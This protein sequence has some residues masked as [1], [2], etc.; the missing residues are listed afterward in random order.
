MPTTAE[1]VTPAQRLIRETHV[2]R[3]LIASMASQRPSYKATDAGYVDREGGGE[4]IVFDLTDG[5]RRYRVF[6][7]EVGNADAG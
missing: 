4:V 3:A 1:D 6:V 2:A 5:G 7:V